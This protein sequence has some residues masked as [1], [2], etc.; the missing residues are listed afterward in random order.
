M[1]LGWIDFSKDE[2]NK[3]LSVIHLLD[4]PGAVDE[5][6]IGAIRDA[7]ADFFF[8]GTSTVQTRA[9]YFLVVP[10]LLQEAC[11][12]NYG[13][14]ANNIIRRIDYEE[15]KC[16]D[17]FLKTSSD[18]VIGSLVPQSWVQR[19]PLSI[20]WTGLK[21]LGIITEDV[22]LRELIQQSLLQKSLKKAKE[23]GNRDKEAEENEKDDFDAGD[24]SSFHFL[25]IG[26]A[27][28]SDWR[29]D[30]TIE[31]EPYEASFLRGQIIR[32]QSKTL[33]AYILKNNVP[34]E[35]YS[36]IAALSE[37]IVNDVEPDLAEMMKLA[38]DFNNLVSIITTRFNLIVSQG[39]NV[40]AVSKWKE[41][42]GDLRRRSTVDLKQI[43]TRLDIKNVK[44]RVF[45]SR[46]Q[47]A[48]WAGNIDVV[49]DLIIDREVRIKGAS[50]AKTKHSGQYRT[51]IW[52]GINKLD[53][54]F[55]SAKRIIVDIMN[56]E[57]KGNV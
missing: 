23:F 46:V 55:T 10:Y 29:D 34:I 22:S 27:Y 51:D 48:I 41:M 47:E 19:T 56:A 13:T 43:Y 24:I 8:P 6:G 39:E 16:R 44:L 36:S 14:E 2:R 35:Q 31:L 45:L 1:Q 18:G 49:D 38:N 50:R 32:S 52:I 17:I 7:F 3:V 9:K 28:K 40:D 26:D 4:E 53:Y 33:F 42:S 5:L 37:D 12:G 20:Y 30:L 21:R 25:N 54:R 15:R 57:G 11:S